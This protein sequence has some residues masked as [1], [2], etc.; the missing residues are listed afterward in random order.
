MIGQPVIIKKLDLTTC[1]LKDA[2]CVNPVNFNIE[3]PFPVTVSGFAGWF[4]VD[5][6][7]SP[8]NPVQKRV[9]L[10]TGPEVGTTHWGQQVRIFY[11]IDYLRS[12]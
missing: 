8:E 11:S 5:F 3:V 10:S 6:N 9:V 1:T 2:E 7:G 12:F 4:T